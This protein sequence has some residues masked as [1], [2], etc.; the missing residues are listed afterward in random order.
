MVKKFKSFFSENKYILISG[1]A[2]LFI[3]LLVY[4]CYE[5]IPFG[6]KTVY[7]MD[8]Y[9]Q[10]GPLFSELYDRLTSGQSLIYSWN[11]GLGGS[12]LGNFF[13]YLSSP[14][15]FIILFFGHK[16]TFEAIAAMI[17]IKSV[18][19]AMSMSYYLKKSQKDNTLAISAFG[20]MYAFCGYFIAYYWNIMWIDAMYIL[21]FVILG[22]ERIIAGGKSKTY[23]LA[24]MLA[25]FSN[26]YI[27]YM[28][29]IFSVIYFVYYYFCSIGKLR[30]SKKNLEIKK[31]PINKLKNSFF[32][33]SGFK[34]A[35]ASISA[36]II[37][38]FML[39]PVAFV[40][41]SSSAT[42]GYTLTE[43]KFYYNIFDFLA[44]HL[45]SLE[46]TIRSSGEDVLP[47]IYCGILTI[48]LIPL[49]MFSKKIP[50]V[51]KIATVVLL[52]VMYFSFNL[53]YLNFAWHGF[54][55]P[56]DLP[57]R[58]SFMYSFILLILAFMAFKNIDEFKKEHILGI[59]LA[60]SAFIIIAEKVGSKNIS[61]GSV[62]ISLI[63]VILF[64]IV[65]G[66][67]T[68][69]KNQAFA[70]SV[71]MMCSVSAEIITAN[72]DH[73]VANQTKTA[74]SSDYDDFKALQTKVDNYDDGMFYRTEMSSLRARM[75]PSWYG[76][77]GVSVFS[78]MA[79][80]KVANLQKYIG[81]Y[82][83]KI[84]SYTY[85]PQTPIYNAMFSL[86]YVYDKK[87]YVSDSDYY[88]FKTANDTF[89]A[90]ENNYMLNIAYPVSS[91][92]TEWDASIYVD[93]VSAQEE[94]FRLA[95]GVDGVFTRLYDYDIVY[96]NILQIG[97]ESI[98]VGSLPFNK[99]SSGIGASVEAKITAKS[100]ENIYIYVYS[101]N[102]DTVTVTSPE[103]TTT[104]TVSDGYILDLGKHYTGETVSVTLPLKD[105]VDSAAVDFVAFTVDKD[106]FIEGYERLK[107]GQ[108]EYT[109][110]DETYI[111]GVFT[112][113]NDEVLYTSIPYDE[114][115]HIYIDGERVDSE[116]IFKISDALLGIKVSEGEHDITFVY[117]AV[118]L[119]YSIIISAAFIILLVI[120]AL[121]KKKHWLFF[122]NKRPDLWERARNAVPAANS[123]PVDENTGCEPPAYEDT[124]IFFDD[125]YDKFNDE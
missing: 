34:F 103:I 22:I 82:G 114:G 1:A 26:Y 112:A 58:Q 101:R 39:V 89:T 73:Y 98:I 92:I 104:M 107:D 23:L 2:A 41:R 97:E 65:L 47:N 61:H 6:D 81:L 25:I 21:P 90:Y 16:N 85:N 24:L 9:H 99:I 91:E 109:K 40:L 86:K 100:D 76:Y 4:F 77:N 94:Y 54:H 71:L 117:E 20:I 53:N 18:L 3:M 66:L 17:A 70:L 30:K 13:N 11:T 74:F 88:T 87:N 37:L 113:E 57:Y 115:W 44:N 125:S 102:L 80:E 122:K 72:T 50:S 83:N 78:S 32:F 42:A 121:L 48:I 14:I 15:S 84:N 45:A 31:G 118:G 67:I 110:F 111:G 123:E 10:Y 51:E 64:S 105:D 19:S 35:F 95:T 106:K 49:Y 63:F 93:P 33:K 68:S 43:G 55:F 29:C 79:Y 7:R 36:V 108:L 60:V 5:I 28:I 12:F 75:D 69:K 46:P 38:L 116:D 119:K 124:T 52:I 62:Y 59:G 8:L 96:D 56:N 27:G 120:F